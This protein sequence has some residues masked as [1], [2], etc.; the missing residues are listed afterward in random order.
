MSR[1]LME[2]DKDQVRDLLVKWTETLEICRDGHRES[3]S[4]CRDP[5]IAR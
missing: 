4:G 1:I 3:T 2:L 5:D